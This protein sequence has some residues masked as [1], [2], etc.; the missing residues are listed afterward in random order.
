MSPSFVIITTAILVAVP[1]ALLGTLLVLRQM[2]MMGDALSHS[3]LPGIVIAFFITESLGPIVSLVG[4]TVFG[5][6]TVA[7]VE[8]LKNTGKVK[9]ESSIGTTFTAMFGLGVFLISRFAT[10]VPL[11]L[12]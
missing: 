6:L 10:G 3:V 4:A 9:E 2:A 12:P 1:C 5:L 7:L 8:A 11:A